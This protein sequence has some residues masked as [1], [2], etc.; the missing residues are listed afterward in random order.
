MA[1]RLELIRI[2]YLVKLSKIAFL[3]PSPIAIWAP[4]SL[5]KTTYIIFTTDITSTMCIGSKSVHT[6]CKHQ[7]PIEILERCENF[8]DDKCTGPDGVRIIWYKMISEPSLCVDCYRVEEKR[9]FE[10]AAEQIEYST[11]E[12]W[13]LKENKKCARTDAVRHEIQMR[14]ADHQYFL[15]LEIKLRTQHLEIFRKEQGVWGDG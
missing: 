9:I 5:H 3:S 12:I 11:D 7:K 4:E 1:L 10:I 8:E 13:L 6:R 2:I 15:N 14:I